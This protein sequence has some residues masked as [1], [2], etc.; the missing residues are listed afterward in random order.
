MRISVKDANEI[1]DKLL[2]GIGCHPDIGSDC[3]QA[4]VAA[5]LSGVDTHG[6]NLLPVILKR[7]GA[8]RSQVTN[9]AVIHELEGMAVQSVDARLTPGQHSCMVATR[10]AINLAE[11]YGV[12][13]VNVKN[14]THFGCCTPFLLE[15][16]RNGMVGLVGSNSLRSMAAFGSTSANLGNNPFGF[17]APSHTHPFLFD[18]S[19]AKMSFGRR[20]QLLR[21]GEGIPEGNFVKPEFRS[22]NGVC[23][24]ADS[25][26]EVALPFGDFKGA[27][28]A[29]MIEV[30]AGLLSGGA[31]GAHTETFGN[32][33]QFLGACHFVFAIKPEVSEPAY[34]ELATSY[35]QNM[36]RGQDLRL[37]GNHAAEER[38][39]RDRDGIPLSEATITE[40][41]NWSRELELE[42][43][44]LG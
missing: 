40:L 16:A 26:S 11:N 2:R 8:G 21:Q 14:S 37:P 29:I 5:S 1:C 18:F 20:A 6:V 22:E 31:T 3:T 35:F 10:S 17:V 41:R 36:Y 24:I 12:G 34:I 38:E 33:G 27:S 39:T 25:L 43:A 7:V 15:I 28:V 32:E 9:P 4:L 19:S 30:M 23:E 44:C 42:L 13:Y